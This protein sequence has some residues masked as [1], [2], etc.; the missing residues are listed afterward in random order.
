MRRP[1][2]AAEQLCRDPPIRDIAQE[3]IAPLPPGNLVQNG[4]RRVSVPML[5]SRAD[6]TYFSTRKLEN[7]RGWL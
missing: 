4:Q 1:P 2:P 6:S 5:V 3:G 7:R